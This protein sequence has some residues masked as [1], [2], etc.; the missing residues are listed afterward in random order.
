VRA[1]LR[2]TAAPPARIVHLGL[3]AFHRAHQAW[4]THAA[5]DAAE[6]GIIAFTGRSAAL[7]LALGAQNNL[8]H[9][10]IRGS[11]G[12][13]VELIDSLVET[14]AGSDV[15]AWS[16]AVAS[17]STAVVTLTVTENA[18][19]Y[20]ASGEIDITS[21][22]VTA[23]LQAFRG[24]R[25]D[26]LTSVPGRL[27]AGLDARRRAGAGPLSIV[28]CDNLSDNAGVARSVVTGF[29]DLVDPAL[30]AWIRDEVSFVATMV[31]RITPATTPELVAAVANLTGFDDA[32]PVV[33]EPFTEW[34]LSG[35]FPA[36]RPNWQSASSGC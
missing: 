10:V 33:T 27:V 5:A 23:D 7:A 4:Y 29:A 2:T 13:Q 25:I 6:W 20:G 15:A 14:R 28:P 36:G 11:T 1:L 32:C 3:G 18:Y 26:A 8:Y 34:V 21:P 24:G 19:C 35:G 12:D 31:D 22:A 16:A 9:L 30:A 17:P